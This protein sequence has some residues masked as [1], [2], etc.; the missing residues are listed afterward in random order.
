MHFLEL[1]C[2]PMGPAILTPY[3]VETNLRVRCPACLQTIEIAK[4]QLGGEIIC[5][6]LDCKT[7]LKINPFVTKQA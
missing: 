3:D 4:P 1:A 7:P 2:F 6:S 5:P